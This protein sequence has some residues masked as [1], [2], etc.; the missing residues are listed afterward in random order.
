MGPY[1]LSSRFHRLSIWTGLIWKTQALVGLIQA[2]VIA[3]GKEGERDREMK[4]Q[5]DGRKE[6]WIMDGWVDGWEGGGVDGGWWM[7]G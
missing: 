6:G 5:N 7:D 1:F 3:S 2:S 4:G